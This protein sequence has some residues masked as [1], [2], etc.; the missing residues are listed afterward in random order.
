VT[1]EEVIDRADLGN[2][3]AYDAEFIA[4]AKK[5]RSFLITTDRQSIRS[6][7]KMVKWLEEYTKEEKL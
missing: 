4:V 5:T 3:S 2:I 6:F 1:S 7:P